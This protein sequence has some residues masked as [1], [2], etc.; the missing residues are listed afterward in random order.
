MHDILYS[1]PI[2]SAQAHYQREVQDVFA[3][4]GRS[5]GLA[6]WSRP[7]EGGRGVRGKCRML[8]NA[9]HNLTCARRAPEPVIQLWPTFG[10]LEARLWASERAPRYVVLHDPTPL[11]R[12]Y[13]HSKRAARWASLASSTS[14]PTILV[15]SEAAEIAAATVL[16]YHRI[17]HVLHPIL[18]EQRHV[19]KS[20]RPTVVVAGQ[21]KPARDLGLLAE[22]GARLRPRGWD[23]RIVGRGWPRVPGWDVEDRF[24]A[25]SELDDLLGRAWV[26]LLPYT[27]YFQSGIAVR[28]LENGTPT[29]GESTDFLRGLLGSGHPGLVPVGSGADGY[30]TALA[31]VVS[32]GTLETHSVFT[33]YRERSH[34]S[35]RKIFPA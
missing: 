27:S 19:D 3:S 25:E 30:E 35:W 28:A 17:Q 14:R 16:P 4:A 26:F 7:A 22:L 32:S 34:A 33:D 6:R 23:L 2:P 31:A 5:T 18:S 21:F 8:A 1:D 24:V 13:G 12:Q 29:V 20:E 9:V 10:L 11:R 15:H